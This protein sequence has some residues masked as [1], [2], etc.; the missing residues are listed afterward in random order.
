ATR[1]SADRGPLARLPARRESED[2]RLAGC[3]GGG[4]ARAPPRPQPYG[5]PRQSRGAPLSPGERPERGEQAAVGPRQLVDDREVI[6]AIERHVRAGQPALLPRRR[7]LRGLADQLRQLAEAHGDDER[8]GARRQMENGTVESGL[9]GIQAE[10]VVEVVEGDRLEVVDVADGQ[11][12]GQAGI[13]HRYRRQVRDG[14]VAS[15]AH[16][17][18]IAAKPL[19]AGGAAR[20]VAVAPRRPDGGAVVVGGT[21]RGA[22]HAPVE[23]RDLLALRRARAPRRVPSWRT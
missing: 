11:P 7:E 1:L 19:T 5:A 12:A 8:R 3:L 16:A 23:H 17:R 21:Q 13:L 9:V 2:P 10:L 4:P 6:V 14:R 15:R 22:V 20:D 18:R